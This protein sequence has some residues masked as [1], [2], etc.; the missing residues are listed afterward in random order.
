[1]PESLQDQSAHRSTVTSS[2][3]N[4]HHVVSS[5]SLFIHVVFI[6][7]ILNFE[8]SVVSHLPLDHQATPRHILIKAQLISSKTVCDAFQYPIPFQ[9]Q[10]IIINQ[11]PNVAGDGFERRTP[12]LETYFVT[13]RLQELSV[14]K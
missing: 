6:A 13:I 9:M 10:I 4:L 11:I 1:M 2:F 14:E 3:F 5:P 7:A 8:P 12:D